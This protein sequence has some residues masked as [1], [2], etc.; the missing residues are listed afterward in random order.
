M[1]NYL[2]ASVDVRFI[3]QIVPGGLHYVLTDGYYLSRQRE[4]QNK[5][6]SDD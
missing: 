3:F 5:T 1:S 4:E 6:A 2:K